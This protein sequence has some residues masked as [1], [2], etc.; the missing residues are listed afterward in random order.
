MGL[1]SQNR[2]NWS[3]AFLTEHLKPKRKLCTK[4]HS[5]LFGGSWF[6]KFLT[7]CELFC[8]FFYKVDL[9]KSKD[10]I[11]SFTAY[12][13]IIKA[14][15]FHSKLYIYIYSTYFFIY[16][17]IISQNVNIIIKKTMAEKVTEWNALP[18]WQD[19]N[20][21]RQNI[22]AHQCMNHHRLPFLI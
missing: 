3:K 20:P 4:F 10:V 6:W 22:D 12:H 17:V 19:I 21:S 16:K 7:K 1:R 2:P 18:W 15:F 5:T 9:L 11:V 13:S 14:E 8:V